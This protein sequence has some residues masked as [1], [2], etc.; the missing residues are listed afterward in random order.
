MGTGRHSRTRRDCWWRRHGLAS[1]WFL[2]RNL[3]QEY[4]AGLCG[5]KA[6]REG[7]R[8]AQATPQGL[9]L[10]SR[11]FNP[12]IVRLYCPSHSVAALCAANP[13]VC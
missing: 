1:N 10:T 5:T 2:R 6:T 4:V 13:L 8:A 9:S 11:G 12:R 7:L 3:R